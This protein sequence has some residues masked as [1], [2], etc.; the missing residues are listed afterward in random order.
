[1]T[2]LTLQNPN[3]GIIREAPVGFSWTTFFLGPFPALFRGD[4]KWFFIQLVLDSLLVIPILV[5]PFIYNKLYLKKLLEAGYK[6]KSV[7]GMAIEVL[8]RRL[9]LELPMMPGK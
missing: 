3:S 1:M 9:G 6:V 4:F 5:F 7:E 8:N 2:K